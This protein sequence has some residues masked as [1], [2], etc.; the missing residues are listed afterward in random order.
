MGYRCSGGAAHRDEAPRQ[1]LQ[2]VKQS[3]AN[4]L[5]LEDHPVV[6]PARQQVHRIPAPIQQAQISLG[7]G[8][9]DDTGCPLAG[10][11]GQ[12]ICDASPL[13]EEATQMLV[14]NPE[15]Y[16]LPRKFKISIAGCRVWCAYPEIND[17]GL[18]AVTRTLNGR[19]EVGFSLRVGGGLSAEP[20]LA[21]RLNAFVGWNQVPEVVKGIA[22]L[23]R[24]SDQLREHRERARL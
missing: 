21:T 24:D 4:P 13:A 7:S 15:F 19:P 5:S 17:I 2:R 11:D 14:G 20:H 9:A 23:F 10:V 16:N 12:E 6:V 3:L 1:G 22:K 18:T 8:S